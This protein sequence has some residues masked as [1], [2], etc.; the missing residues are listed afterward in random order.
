MS[1]RPLGRYRYDPPDGPAPIYYGPSNYPGY[2]DPGFGYPKYRTP[3]SEKDNPPLSGTR[4]SANY[5]G[6]PHDWYESGATLG[7]RDRSWQW[8]PEY[9]RHKEQYDGR[10]EADFARGYNDGY[11]NRTT[12]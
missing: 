11:S 1:P 2:A 3:A 12:R 9:R 7:R 6:G 10:T 8:S 5:R 4:K